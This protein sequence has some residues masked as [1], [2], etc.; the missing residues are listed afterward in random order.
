MSRGDDRGFAGVI[1]S[2]DA[3]RELL[4]WFANETLDPAERRAVERHL[5]T[6][7]DCSDELAAIR[8][9]QLSIREQSDPAALR[10]QA[11]GGDVA[12]SVPAASKA[13]SPF[14]RGMLTTWVVAGQAAAILLLGVTLVL[15]SPWESPTRDFELRSA[16]AL[17]IDGGSYRVVFEDAATLGEVRELL[18]TLDLVVTSGPSPMGVYTLAPAAGATTP[19]NGANGAN[20]ANDETLVDLRSSAIVRLAEPIPSN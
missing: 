4:P 9:L 10:P 1:L 2:H 6:C 12:P 7:E 11:D 15:Q 14:R 8:E 20:D 19:T 5:A 3:C 17:A 13:R 16:S 18:A